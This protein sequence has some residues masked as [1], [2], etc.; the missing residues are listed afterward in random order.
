MNVVAN[1]TMAIVKTQEVCARVHPN[2]CSSGRTKTLQAY[3]DRR[4]GRRRPRD[5]DLHAAEC[6]ACPSCCSKRQKAWRQDP[7]QRRRRCNV[8]NI[9][10]TDAT[11]GAGTA[12]I[13]RRVL[14]AFPVRETIAFFREI[15]VPLHEEADGKLFPDS[16]RAR[17]VLD[18]LLRE[19]GRSGVTLLADHRVL[20]VTRTATASASQPPA[21]IFMRG[22]SCS[23]PAGS[24]AQ[25]RKRRRGFAIARRLGHTIVPTTPGLAPWSSMTGTTANRQCLHRRLAGVSQDGELTIWIDGAVAHAAARVAALDALRRERS[26]G[27][28]RVAALAPGAARR[29]GR[30]DHGQLLSGRRLRTST[31]VDGASSSGPGVAVRTALSTMVPASVAAALV[32]RLAIDGGTRLA[33]L[34]REDRRRLAH[35]LVAWPLPVA[36]TRGY[37]YAEV[38]AGGVALAEIDPA[39]MQSRVCPG[40]IW[41]GRFSTWTDESADSTFSGRGRAR[42]RGRRSRAR[43]GSAPRSW[44][45]LP[46]WASRLLAWPWSRACAASLPGPAR[47]SPA[48]RPGGSR[49]SRRPCSS[50]SITVW[51]S[52]TST[53]VP[54]P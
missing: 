53:S 42:G 33:H 20:D 51:C 19:T 10:V 39:T 29:E 54:A 30:R 52:L 14:R 50:K 41:W 11:S 28:E 15:G 3:D 48:G 46:S 44:P 5:R 43:S 18:A 17:D 1:V 24:P 23:R 4:R 21:A 47:W 12:T 38:T 27:D 35:A 25:E 49:T 26:R 31:A 8:T 22:P 40:C 7:R 16:N 36:G 34:S 2:S 13:V 32:E 37:N 6:P 45:R 9:V